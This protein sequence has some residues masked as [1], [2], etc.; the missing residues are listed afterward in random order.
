MAN[1]ECGHQQKIHFC[2]FY[3]YNIKNNGNNNINSNENIINCNKSI[4]MAK[5]RLNAMNNKIVNHEKYCEM[6]SYLYKSINA[7]QNELINMYELNE[8]TL[9]EMNNVIK[10]QFLSVLLSISTNVWQL[11]SPRYTGYASKII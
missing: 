7:T 3:I 4:K 5:E 2:H 6:L 1:T 9:S 10:M 8:I 11:N